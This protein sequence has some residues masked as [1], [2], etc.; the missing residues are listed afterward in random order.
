MFQKAFGADNIRDVLY[1][2]H[3]QHPVTFGEV[4]GTNEDGSYKM[5][6]T[7][8]TA[9]DGTCFNASFDII[10]YIDR[11]GGKKGSNLDV[12]NTWID[13]FEATDPQN[14][15]TTLSDH[16]GVGAHF[17]RNAGSK[18]STPRSSKDRL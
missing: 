4:I 12:T 7:T 10:L 17:L 18:D 5:K 9:K 13:R 2:Q 14:R 11:E 16:Y 8:L 15:F 1:E 3:G 6:E